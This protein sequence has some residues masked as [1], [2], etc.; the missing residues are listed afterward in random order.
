MIREWDKKWKYCI[1]KDDK[2]EESQKRQSESSSRNEETIQNLKMCCN[3]EGERKRVKIYSSNS[4]FFI[5][6]GET[7][8]EFFFLRVRK[9]NCRKFETK[10]EKKI[11]RVDL[12][13]FRLLRGLN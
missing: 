4:R 11:E 1:R 2:G 8:I 12:Q 9:L 3:T 10:G 5:L 6:N 13:I 7:F